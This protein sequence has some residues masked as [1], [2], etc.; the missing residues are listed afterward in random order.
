MNKK[1]LMSML[2]IMMVALLSV[3][4]VSCGD[5]DE[6]I[7]YSKAIVGTWQYEDS[8]MTDV[9]SF[10]S[11]GKCSE[12]IN[13]KGSS[14]AIKMRYEGNFLVTEKSLVLNWSKRVGW[15]PISNDWSIK[16][17]S[18]VYDY[19]YTLKGKTLIIG[20]MTYIKQ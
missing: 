2:S 4:F 17:D 6:E 9:I 19:S 3:G 1:F 15:N 10:F 12:E 16:L 20:E 8:E 13:V 14:P 18:K 7:D 5:D 11:S